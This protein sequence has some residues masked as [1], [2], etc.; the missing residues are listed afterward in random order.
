MLRPDPDDGLVNPDRDRSH[1]PAG[2]TGSH[3]IRDR[4][5]LDQPEILLDLA[6]TDR[7][8]LYPPVARYGALRAFKARRDAEPTH[9]LISG[10][11]GARRQL[12]D[13]RSAS[14]SG[15]LGAARLGVAAPLALTP[16][17]SA[18]F[19]RVRLGE[20]QGVG[21]AL[22]CFQAEPDQTFG[23]RD[24]AG[25]PVEHRDFRPPLEVAREV[26][27][28]G[29]AEHDRLGAVFGERARN[30]R[31]NPVGRRSPA[32]RAPAPARRR[33]APGRSGRQVRI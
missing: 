10:I 1:E 13:R 11:A 19:A 29:A 3:S 28:A 5:R 4:Q 16:A 14:A 8:G 6:V 24:G 15:A 17:R 18:E 23:E 32:P 21:V 20:R 7:H 9:P 27:H 2:Q 22:R 12:P 26:G 33:P 25:D 30:L 31:F